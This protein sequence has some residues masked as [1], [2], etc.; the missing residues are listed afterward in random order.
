MRGGDM[1]GEF[2]FPAG[3]RRGMNEAKSAWEKLRNMNSPRGAGAGAGAG[4]GGGGGMEGGERLMKEKEGEREVEQREFDEM[5]E[6]ER[7][8]ER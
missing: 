2:Q 4:I 6:R 5:L 7:Q 3:Q 8:G 1:V